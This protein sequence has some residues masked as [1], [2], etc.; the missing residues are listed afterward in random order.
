MIITSLSLLL[1]YCFM[2]YLREAD[3]RYHCVAKR[4][5]YR[6]KNPNK[7]KTPPPPPPPTHTKKREQASYFAGLAQSVGRLNRERKVTGTIPG[8]RTI[9]GI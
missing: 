7:K 9:L 1:D 5:R 6:K 8:V 4:E 3:F 2:Y